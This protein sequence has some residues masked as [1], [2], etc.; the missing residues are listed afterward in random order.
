MRN[1][2]KR[3]LFLVFK[4]VLF[5]NKKKP[6]ID[7]SSIKN[8]LIIQAG[9]VGDVLRIFPAVK[10]LCD[11]LP[12]SSISF[13]VFPGV[14]DIFK[15]L[16]NKERIREIID[17]EPEGTH[18]GIFK[19][20]SLI[21]LLRKNKY[22]LIYV[23]SRGKGTDG[24]LLMAFFAGARHRIGF[25]VEGAG[26]LNTVSLKFKNNVSISEQ[27]LFLL[28]AAGLKVK[29]EKTVLDI[30]EE[31]MALA[32][33]LTGEGGF[34]TI[35]S[36]HPGA[37]WNARYRCWPEENY[38]SLVKALVSEGAQVVIIG[39]KDE[40]GGNIARSVNH[41]AVIDVTGKLTIPQLAAVIKLSDMLIGNDSGPL[42]IAEATSTPYIGI[43]GPTS[44]R[45]VLSNPPNITGIGLHGNLSCGPCYT[46][47]GV[48][49]P[50]CE[51]T[52]CRNIETVLV[53]EVFAAAKGFMKTINE[54]GFAL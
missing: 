7:A 5:F 13:L 53:K 4:G 11:N 16:P 32:R 33:G 26:F 38:I 48:F 10:S 52:R 36:L 46:H 17:Y 28:D 31:D 29:R 45:Q 49:K 21:L 41:N 3:A 54:R 50:V 34:S 19:R 44:P 51:D 42:H 14:K 43:F 6:A 22:D 8:I 12:A 24:T 18:K 25:D 1:L 9:G 23:P 15:L 40:M 47:Q 35:I 37:V 27:N 20:M 30:P 2:L 39:S